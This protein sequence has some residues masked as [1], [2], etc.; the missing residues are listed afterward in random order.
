[1]GRAV[2]VQ[3]WRRERR[4]LRPLASLARRFR[5]LP[6][7]RTAGRM[8]EVKKTSK[9]AQGGC[10]HQERPD[11]CIS[12]DA[13][14][15]ATEAR[16][17]N[18]SCRRTFD[19]GGRHLIAASNFG[20]QRHH[21]RFGRCPRAQDHRGGRAVTDRDRGDVQTERLDTVP[22]GASQGCPRRCPQSVHV[23]CHTRTV[24]QSK[25]SKP[26]L[27]AGAAR[28]ASTRACACVSALSLARNASRSLLSR[29]S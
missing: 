26:E 24:C 8:T 7:Q 18:G 1:M 13:R 20:G 12:A 22:A 28:L 10:S 9:A 11:G 3:V 2:L 25:T 27:S 4:V 14:E 17:H 5:S 15:S 19:G 16:C 21:P 29:N 23:H 6:R